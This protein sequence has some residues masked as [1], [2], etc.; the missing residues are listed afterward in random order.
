MV[1]LTHLG[2]LRVASIE[3]H[4][5]TAPKVG[6]SKVDSAVTAVG[7]AEEREQCLI[8]ADWQQL[9]SADLPALRRVAEGDCHYLSEKRFACHLY[10]PFLTLARGKPRRV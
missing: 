6:Q 5:R 2:A 1:F 3:A 8:L 7:C 4:S 10:C 9:S